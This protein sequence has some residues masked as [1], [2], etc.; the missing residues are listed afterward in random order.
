MRS[1][2]THSTTCALLLLPVLVIAFS[3][4]FTRD[5]SAAY[6]TYVR[7]LVSNSAPSSTSTSHTVTFTL[8]NAVPANGKIMLT[9]AAAFTIPGALDF[10]DIDLSTAVASSGPF[11]ERSL[12]TLPSAVAD[13]VGVASGPPSMITLTLSSGAGIAASSTVAIEIGSIALFGGAGDQFITSPSTVGSHRINIETRDASDVQIDV[14]GAIIAIVDPVQMSAVVQQFPPPVLSNGLP[15]GLL[16][17]TTAS[18]LMSLNTNIFAMCKYA[19]TAGVPYFTMSSS[20]IFTQ[21]N[22]ATLHYIPVTTATNTIYNFYVRCA[23]AQQIPNIADYLINFEVGVVPSAT[24]TPPAPPPPPPSGGGGPSGPGGGGGLFLSG[25][26]VTIEGKAAPGVTAVF[27]KDGVNVRESVVSVLGEFSEKFTNLPRGTYTWSVYMRDANGRNS[28]TYSST[29]YLI[30]KSNNIIAPVYLSPTTN[31]SSTTVALG[32]D[33]VLSG[34][35]IALRDVRA[36]MTKQGEASTGKIVTATTTANGSGGWSITL[37]TAGLKK[38]TYEAKM[39]SLISSKDQSLLSPVV[40]VG[41]GEEPNPD[42]GNRSD[43]NKDKK[44]NLVDFSI[45]LFH[46][47]TADETADINQD[48]IVNLTDFSIMLSNWTG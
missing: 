11:T 47:R 33:L 48:G 21:A 28:S 32:G 38:G 16:P 23:N 8:S 43:L 35:A 14:Q 40:Y 44:V 3:S 2:F 18:V 42:M 46:W 22:V 41:I 4:F 39:I 13:G 45:L 36:I 25:G 24:A 29:I 5:A 20:T 27:L 12:A 31:R 34:Y 1:R 9:F 10:T 30:A 7:D 6:L 19:T 15:T 37:P 17:G 26:D